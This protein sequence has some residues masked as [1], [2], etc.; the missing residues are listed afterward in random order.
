LQAYAQ[1]ERLRYIDYHAL[2]STPEGAL[3]P[4]FGIDGVHPNRDGYAVMRRLASAI[5]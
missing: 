5:R 3:Q 2:L 4:A 1:R